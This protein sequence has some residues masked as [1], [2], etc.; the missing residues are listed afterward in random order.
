MSA[1][2]LDHARHVAALGLT[3]HDQPEFQRLVKLLTAKQ[4]FALIFAV[5][6]NPTYRDSIIG[7][8][9]TVPDLAQRGELSIDLATQ[10]P[11]QSG[12]SPAPA[13][14]QALELLLA[15]EA[16]PGCIVHLV[17]TDGWLSEPALR[18]LNLRRNAL[19]TG[20]DAALVWWLPAPV[21]A[22]LVQ[23]APDL[24][25]WRT[26]VLD[27]EGPVVGAVANAVPVPPMSF[28]QRT[29][30]SLAQKGARVAVLRNAIAQIQDPV[31][32]FEL[33]LE[34]SALLVALGQLDDALRCLRQ[35]VLPQATSLADDYLI[36]VTQGKIADVLQA[37]GQLDEALKIRR[38]QEL[39]VYEKLGDVRSLLVGRANMAQLLMQRE[40]PEDLAEAR[41]LLT[42]ALAD[43]RRLQ[44][45][46]SQV[47]QQL[48]AQLPKRKED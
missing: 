12:A 35:Q 7:Q 13:D 9:R 47:I 19:A 33:M 44:L 2:S 27:F 31:Q 6:A 39:P 3:P 8:L 28:V 48:L 21:V 1:F 17:N 5:C 29:S 20:T 45:P 25:A 10:L 41:R 24:W 14:V 36:A 18:T 22:T 42:M 46:E 34:E 32:R 16:A 4:R 30:L 37:R 23:F 11:L 26:G 40:A 38:E 15:N 43:A